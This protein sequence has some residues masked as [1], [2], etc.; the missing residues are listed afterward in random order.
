MN[1]KFTI[2]LMFSLLGCCGFSFAQQLPTLPVNIIPEAVEFYKRGE[3]AIL[4]TNYKKAIRMFEK[5]LRAQPSLSAA[6][7]NIGKCYSLL[8]D[9]ENA[10]L[11]YEIVLESDS[12]FSRA[13]YYELGE[14]Y[15]KAEKFNKALQYFTEF[16]DLQ[17]Q[18]FEE[19]GM[20][21]EKETEQEK[22]YMEKIES[23]IRACHVTLDSINYGK[24]TNIKNLGSS[25]NTGG[26][27]YFPFVTND[28]QMLFFTHSKKYGMDEN[29]YYSTT[30]RSGDWKNRSPIRYFNTPA[31]EGRFTMVR[32]GRKMFFTTCERQ[33]VL[34]ECDI[35]EGEIEKDEIT[36]IQPVPGFLNTMS[37]ESQVSVNCDGSV[38][39]FASMR[40]G[41]FG[42]TDIWYSEKDEYG[43]W[44]E[45]KNL[46]P[47]INTPQNEQAPFITNDGKTLYFSSDGHLGLGGMDIFMSWLNS[48]TAS[49]NAAINLGQPIN[50]PSNEF[51]FFLCADGKTGYFASDKPNRHGSYD[52][53][54]YGFKLSE[55]L[56]NEPITFVEGFV[57]DSIVGVSLPTTLMVK[58][59]GPV[60]TDENG[61][62]FI[63]LPAK[64]TLD[65]RID[66]DQYEFYNKV[67]EI[68]EWDNKKFYS[69]DI[70]LQPMFSIV[71]YSYSPDTTEVVEETPAPKKE[72]QPKEAE[73]KAP[74]DRE[75]T[76][77]KNKLRT[78]QYP[79]IV[80][81]KFDSY[82]LRPNEK[83]K[84]ESFINSLAGKTI[85]RI[86]IIGYADDTGPDTY[87]LQLSTER[88][89]RIALLLKEKRLV[90][91]Q[92]YLEGRGEIKD[93][94]PKDKNR[95][96]DIKVYTQE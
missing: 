66:M 38:L 79:H 48:S 67:F 65:I 64:S 68:P 50:T 95:R 88:A 71:E 25:I 27:E 16:Q 89:K 85:T 75:I 91:N 7:R 45:P 14:T 58:G 31:D 17:T 80:F 19:F 93:D 83:E 40:D 86:E 81:F 69:V 42:G 29:L 22:E 60:T 47:K 92:I 87:N 2:L 10:I 15:Y 52:Y 5:S 72:K 34:G 77:R 20:F 55:E 82:E 30:N 32:D 9:H 56:Y 35:W 46:G 13:L 76:I 57:K 63:C 78:E 28:Q 73:E 8:N 23:N 18:E 39:Y 90:V 1:K 74:K 54:L 70:L 11:H 94:K 84:I 62:F 53:D 6:H 4:E 49:W 96:V 37:W 36:S 59:R 24:I 51:G 21:G 43:Q 3:Q 33:G 12:M 44:G 41:G 61:R 26:N